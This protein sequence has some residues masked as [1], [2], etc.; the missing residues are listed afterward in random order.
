[1]EQNTTNQ[2]TMS[3]YEFADLHADRS[4]GQRGLRGVASCAV[5]IPRHRGDVITTPPTH[6]TTLEIELAQRNI[7]VENGE[8]RNPTSRTSASPSIPGKTG[9]V[10]FSTIGA[11]RGAAQGLGYVSTQGHDVFRYHPKS[12]DGGPEYSDG[13][14]KRFGVA[15]ESSDDLSVAQENSILSCVQNQGRGRS[16]YR[17]LFDRSR[18]FHRDTTPS[19]HIRK[20]LIRT[21]EKVGTLTESCYNKRNEATLMGLSYQPCMDLTN[22]TDGHYKAI[23]NGYYG[24]HSDRNVGDFHSALTA[25]NQRQKLEGDYS[26]ITRERGSARHATPS[27]CPANFQSTDRQHQRKSQEMPP[28]AATPGGEPATVVRT[29]SPPGGAAE[30]SHGSL[31]DVS[32]QHRSSSCAA[33]VT[34][35]G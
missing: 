33:L 7:L 22:R 18:D 31:G 29:V 8:G 34:T 12:V 35:G 19:K 14:I 4:N 20:Q 23:E 6:R 26:I 9:S 17:R 15:T 1:M 28:T 27:E 10:T 13:E 3:S 25:Y 2:S 11:Q 30:V 16:R 32:E 24:E 5:I 21:T